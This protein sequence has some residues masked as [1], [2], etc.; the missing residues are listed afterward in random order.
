MQI[1]NQPWQF[2]NILLI[3]FIAFILN[4]FNRDALAAIIL[5]STYHLSPHCNNLPKTRKI[6]NFGV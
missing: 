3:K 4:K 6:I 2:P 5:Q 1:Y